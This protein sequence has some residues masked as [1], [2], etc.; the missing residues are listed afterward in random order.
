V[1]ATAAKSGAVVV[2][3]SGAIGALARAGGSA[4]LSLGSRLLQLAMGGGGGGAEADAAARERGAERGGPLALLGALGSALS[5]A[6]SLLPSQLGALWQGAGASASACFEWLHAVVQAGSKVQTH[7][8]AVVGTAKGRMT[9]LLVISHAR[10]GLGGS[11][12][13]RR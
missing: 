4:A 10:R 5:A 11:A 13:S 1:A 9:Q 2:L 3:A 8:H 6:L 7:V 12:V